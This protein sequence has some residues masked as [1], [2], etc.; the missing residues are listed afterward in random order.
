LASVIEQEFSGEIEAFASDVERMKAEA[1][2]AKLAE[3]QPEIDAA[4]EQG[5][6]EGAAEMLAL[7]KSRLQIF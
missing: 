3:L 2:A 4:R 5:R 6:K 1:A 7:L